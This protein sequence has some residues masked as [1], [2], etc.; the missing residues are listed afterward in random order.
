LPSSPS[1]VSDAVFREALVRVRG[2]NG[3][4]LHVVAFGL[5]VQYSWVPRFRLAVLLLLHDT[6]PDQIG[7]VEVV[8]PMV[9]PLERQALEEL[10]CIVSP[11]VVQCQ[12]VHEPALIF[13]PYADRVF[14]ENLLI[15]NWSAEQLGKIILLG[16]SFNAIVKMLELS[17][18]MQE[19]FGVT[20][21][22][23]KVRRIH[24]IQNYVREIELCPDFDGLFDNP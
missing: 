1:S 18:S 3:M 15:L 13:M 22:R 20:E 7:A 14:F 17:M 11:S 9:T 4:R 19:K 5:G 8:C 2:D 21:Q 12:P 23:E 10:G 16:Q 24:A 6:F